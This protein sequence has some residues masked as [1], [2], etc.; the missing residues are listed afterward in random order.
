MKLHRFGMQI[1][2]KTTKKKLILSF[3]YGK[4]WLL[5]LLLNVKLGVV[6][7]FQCPN[8]TENNEGEKWENETFLGENLKKTMLRTIEHWLIKKPLS[9]S[10]Q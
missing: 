7:E 9:I 1:S 10:L 4:L 6:V 2:R 3:C 8:F 5:V